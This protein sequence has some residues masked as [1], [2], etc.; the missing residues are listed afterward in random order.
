MLAATLTPLMPPEPVAGNKQG[1][2]AQPWHGGRD[3][4]ERPMANRP[5]LPSLA[6][7]AVRWIVHP[8]P[9]IA[10]AANGSARAAYGVAAVPAPKPAHALD[11]PSASE[12]ACAP[13]CM[14]THC[15]RGY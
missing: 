1:P 7:S 13:I 4:T 8:A 12:P 5:P 9:S 10:Q 14:V 11:L 6:P 15:A 3:P 2:A